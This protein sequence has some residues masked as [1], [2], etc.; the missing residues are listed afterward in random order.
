MGAHSVALRAVRD[1]AGEGLW[2]CGWSKMYVLIGDSQYGAG[3]LFYCAK[4]TRYGYTVNHQG[5]EVW[6]SGASA[7]QSDWLGDAP[8]SPKHSVC[9]ESGEVGED[10]S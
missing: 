2:C 10:A 4:I 5:G 9:W 3:R 7:A 6:G 8:H 1:V